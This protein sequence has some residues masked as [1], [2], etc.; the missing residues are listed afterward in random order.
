[1]KLVIKHLDKVIKELE[2]QAGQEYM[3]G[4]QQECDIF[5][6]D[7]TV[8]R[9]HFKIFQ[10]AE[11]NQW[12]VES[13]SP[14]GGLEAQ[15]ESVSKLTLE[16]SQTLT[17][18]DFS[19]E[20][21]L[22]ESSP[23]AQKT[24][25]FDKKMVTS[26]HL[27]DATKI[28]TS[29]SL[30]RVL[31]ITIEGEASE[32][33]DLENETSWVLGRD[34]DCDIAIDYKVLT[35]RHLKFE[36][37]K[38]NF[39]V[40][41][42]NSSNGSLF[43]GIKMKP[44]VPYDLTV[45]DRISVGDLTI[46]FEVRNKQFNSLM[47]NLP[48]INSSE[49]ESLN[50]EQEM[51]FPKIVLEDAE[52]TVIRKK[53]SPIKKVAFF[54]ILGLVL[55]AVAL[56]DF[57]KEEKKVVKED[58]KKVEEAKF[59]ES[60]YNLAVNFLQQQNFQFCID[61]LE[62][63]H[64]KTPVYLDS[65]RI[66]EKCKNGMELKKK[67]EEFLAN[68]KRRKEAE[69]RVQSIVQECHKQA[70]TFKTEEEVDACAREAL[71]IDPENVI[72]NNIKIALQEKELKKQLK[73]EKKDKY[74]KMIQSK[75]Y[76]F[77]KAER[78]KKQN[79]PLKAVAAYKVFLKSAK[80]VRG[81]ASLYNKAEQT[82]NQIQTD[83]DNTLNSLYSNCKSFMEK[84]QYKSAYYEC[85]KILDFRSED[86]KAIAYI[87]QAKTTLQNQLR[88]TYQES[89]IAESLSKIKKAQELWEKIVAQDV[90]DGHYYKK[91]RFLLNKYK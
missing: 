73:Q 58:K 44:K 14:L 72:I 55:V 70:H 67:N 83:Y 56:I 66:D 89:M 40:T 49:S 48:A 26:T 5:L 86:Q 60:T 54:S 13:L 11:S 43:N 88:N 12:V 74:R 47:D 9:N 35:R 51:A 18:K 28:A 30:M 87:K 10:D 45:D 76:L 61:E 63:L 91:A 6:D 7:Q 38:D 75:K 36:N 19:F 77:K 41:D 65:Q 2:L 3:A 52:E 16:T 90:S 17:L 39:T 71:T 25:L 59:I 8:S 21:L 50:G 84:K 62:K 81:L 29:P 78:Y 64:K 79:K 37:K 31:H 22:E 68:E 23:Q 69:V 1:M 42:L 85:Q 53:S 24:N 34:E 32:Y 27:T 4:R 82:M 46:A 33:I 15:G 20:F 80:G 57:K